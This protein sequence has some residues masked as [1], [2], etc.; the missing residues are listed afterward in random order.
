MDF[1]L[2]TRN[3]VEVG[4]PLRE[5]MGN[6]LDKLGRFFSRILDC[7]VAL[8]FQRGMYVCEVT[9]DANGVIMR[10]EEHATDLRKAFDRAVEKIEAQI[11]RHKKWL[12]DRRHLKTHDMTAEALSAEEAYAEQAVEEVDSDKIREKIVKIKSFEVKPMSPEEAV[13][14]MELLGHNFFVFVEPDSNKL[15]I[16]YKRKD[17]TYGLIR[18]R[19]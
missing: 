8:G 5:H 16:V 9:V 4:E 3:G 1:R 10:G 19:L 15:S 2:F 12:R 7:Q 11:K 14:Q 6:K 17:D 18:P 13:T